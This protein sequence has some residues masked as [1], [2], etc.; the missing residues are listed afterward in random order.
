MTRGCHLYVVAV[1]A[2][3]LACEV[4]ELPP[5]DPRQVLQLCMQVVDEPL[6]ISTDSC[7]AVAVPVPKSLR[8]NN[9]ASG[10]FPSHGT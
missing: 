6:V 2:E 10:I 3:E 9:S 1:A 4:L 7:A 5:V 8:S